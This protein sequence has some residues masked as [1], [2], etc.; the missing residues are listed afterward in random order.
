M[1]TEIKPHFKLEISSCTFLFELVGDA[2]HITA[3]REHKKW[4]ACVKE[5]LIFTQKRIELAPHEMYEL[6][7]LY[8]NGGLKHAPSVAFLIDVPKDTIQIQISIQIALNI[9]HTDKHNIPLE[10]CVEVSEIDKLRLQNEQLLNEFTL[11]KKIIN[12][13]IEKLE[14]ASGSLLE[15]QRYDDDDLH[16]FATFHLV[17]AAGNISFATVFEHYCDWHLKKYKKN[18]GYTGYQL[19]LIFRRN[20]FSVGCRNASTC[21]DNMCNQ[22][23]H[24]HSL[25]GFVLK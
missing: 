9:M 14:N 1:D 22:P 17:H 16:E 23:S 15:Q 18:C 8:Y 7:K 13:R 20:K 10:L 11:F 25:S 19:L 21:S 12:E 4:T 6:F 2:L 24:L 3:T 5:S